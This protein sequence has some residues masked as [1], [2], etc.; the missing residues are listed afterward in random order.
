MPGLTLR[1]RLGGGTTLFA[2][3]MSSDSARLAATVAG[4][5]YDAVIV[6]LQHGE[7]T[8][9]EARDAAA[10]I[11]A[12]GVPFGAR[13][14]LGGLAEAARVLDFGGEI[15]VLPMVSSAEDARAFVGAV[16]YIPLGERSWGPTRA[17]G[18]L[19]LDGETYRAAANRDTVALA[20]I[21]TRAAVDALDAILDVDGLDGVLVGPSDLSISLSNGKALDHRMPE[22]VA[23]MERVVAGCRSRGKVS[24]IFQ[25]GGAAAAASAA[26]GFDLVAVGSDLGFAADGARA[27]LA[28]ARGT[29]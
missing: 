22:A 27:A 6:D 2:A 13:V 17:L 16:K 25:V 28:A 4:T 24:A 29:A 26:M 23:V 1:S 15:V 12:M 14:G 5:G 9:A 18:V 20:M 11:G 8:I 21:E 3:W 19:G 10:A 7:A